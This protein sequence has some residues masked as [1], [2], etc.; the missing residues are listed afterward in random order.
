[1]EV[2]EDR[3]LEGDGLAL[4]AVGADVA[5]DGDLH[6]GPFGVGTPRLVSTLDCGVC[7]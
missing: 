2:A 4:Q 3:G 1:M 7:V 6:G 5:A